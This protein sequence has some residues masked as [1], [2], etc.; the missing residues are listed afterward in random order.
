MKDSFAEYISV[1]VIFFQGLE[2]I[3]PLSKS[4]FL[5]FRVFVENFTA[6]LMDFPT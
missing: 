3:I 1:V 2:D 5:A 6:I 4:T